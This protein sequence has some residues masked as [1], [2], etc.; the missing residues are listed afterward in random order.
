MFLVPFAQLDARRAHL[1]EDKARRIDAL[2]KPLIEVRPPV[3]LE[4]RPVANKLRPALHRDI[5]RA[6]E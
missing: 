1:E 5:D 3:L 4:S 2:L 6:R